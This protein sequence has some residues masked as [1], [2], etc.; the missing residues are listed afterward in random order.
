MIGSAS[1]PIQNLFEH[2]NHSCQP[3]SEIFIKKRHPKSV[4]SKDMG[5]LFMYSQKHFIFHYTGRK[6]LSPSFRKLH[7]K[8]RGQRRPWARVVNKAF[9]YGGFY[10]T[11]R[12]HGT[13]QGILALIGLAAGFLK[14]SS[15]TWNFGTNISIF[16]LKFNFWS[17]RYCSIVWWC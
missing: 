13:W 2:S 4:L 1:I 15:F 6:E 5:N 9:S 16:D 12:S 14:Y 7:G 11:V 8:E 3:K 10:I 17:L